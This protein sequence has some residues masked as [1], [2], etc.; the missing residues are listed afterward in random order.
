MAKYRNPWKT[1]AEVHKN[2]HYLALKYL[3]LSPVYWFTTA[4]I[5][6]ELNDLPPDETYR[7]LLALYSNGWIEYRD[8]DCWRIT[9]LGVKQLARL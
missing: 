4:T 5:G 1:L 7:V 8:S 9:P 2:N 6:I 3:S